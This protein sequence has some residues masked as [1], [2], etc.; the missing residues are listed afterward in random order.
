MTNAR[1]VQCMGAANLSSVIL[2][3]VIPS[4]GE[5]TLLDS[6]SYLLYPLLTP[7]DERQ[8]SSQGIL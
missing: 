1:A 3:F 4:L 6:T 5:E 7:Q 2:S 8:S